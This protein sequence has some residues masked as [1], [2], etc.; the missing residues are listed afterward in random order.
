MKTKLC[1]KTKTSKTKNTLRAVKEVIRLDTTESTQD[2][3]KELASDGYDA[4]TLV[5]AKSQTKGRGRFER[6]WYS[7]K[8]G[9][10]FSIILR[11]KVSSQSLSKL[12][13]KAAKSVSETLKSLYGI[14]TKIKLPN[15]VLAYYPKSRK[16]LKIAG[17]L[18]E[19]S[20]TSKIPEWIVLGVGVDLNN[21]LPPKLKEAVTVKKILKKPVSADDFLSKFFDIFWD[22]YSQWEIPANLQIR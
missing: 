1:A 18:I 10:Y 3:A 11:P 12:S 6:K 4:N 15:D 20:T 16:F 22:N 2:I 13:I 9:L 8:G 21:E 7:N 17:I 19:S 14:K 5:V